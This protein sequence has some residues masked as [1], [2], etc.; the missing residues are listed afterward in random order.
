V[1]TLRIALPWL[2]ALAILSFLFYRIDA[3]ATWSALADADVAR[4]VVLACGFSLLWLAI[5]AAVLTRLFGALGAELG[6]L[7]MARERAATYPLMI[8]SFH[9][10]SAALVARLARRTRARLATLGG[11]MLVHYAGD[12]AALCSVSLAGALTLDG[13]LALALRL[14][15][16]LLALG[17]AALL[18]AGRLARRRLIERPVVEALALLSGADLALLFAGRC[19]WYASFGAFVWST[20]PCFDL[21]FSLG[22]V[23]ARV[24]IVL[25]VAG[26]P[27]APAGIG[28]AQA[29]LLALFDGLGPQPRLFAYGLVFGATLIVLR[30]PIG[31]LALWRSGPLAHG[32]VS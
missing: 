13:R 14:P 22:D 9:L 26:L 31:A 24:P 6:W 32:E 8:V 28:T 7:E 18:V 15:L 20:A 2:G 27:I 23:A 11:G 4:Y 19:A 25:A 21:A 5:D 30:L 1:K 16:A 10:A 29:A 3:Q 17:S 12:L